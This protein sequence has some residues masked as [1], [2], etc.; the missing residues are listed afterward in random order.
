M[1][2]ISGKVVRGIQKGRKLGFP[3]ANIKVNFDLDFGIY[4]GHII[5]AGK[6]YNSAIYSPGDKI[7]EAFIFDFSGDL[8]DKKVGVEIIKK[9]RDKKNFKSD[10]EAI[11]QITKDISKIKKLLEK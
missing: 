8:Y 9:I 11:K 4:A 5:I 10:A 7:I 3:T 2:N 6:K 1:K